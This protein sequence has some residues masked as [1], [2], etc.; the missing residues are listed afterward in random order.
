MN[1]G[2]DYDMKYYLYRLKFETPVRFGIDK[3]SS[4]LTTTAFTANSDT[5]FSAIAS[6]WARIYGSE[7]LET[8]INETMNERFVLSDLLPYKR[9]SEE[10]EIYIPKPILYLEKSKEKSLNIEEINTDK[11]KIKKITHIGISEIERYMTYLKSGG[12]ISFGMVKESIYAEISTT[13]AYVRRNEDTLPYYVAGVKFYSDAGLCFVT[14]TTERIKEKLDIVID[15]LSTSGIGGKK[16]SGFG[17]F[18]SDS[19]EIGP[20]SNSVELEL[21]KM[22][23]KESSHYI[24]ISAVLP[25]KNEID[26]VSGQNCGYQLF[27][28]K[29]FISSIDFGQGYYK[30][31]QVVMIKAGSVFK[32]KIKGKI[33]DVSDAG[34]HKVYRNGKGMYLGVEEN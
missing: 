25:E 2:G 8:F 14:K 31:K 3:A 1:N 13:K 12:K 28:R 22:L 24:S 27:L 20:N 5:V 21:W 4:N 15:S 18:I 32:Y 29:G 9:S 10:Y 6:E 11:K 33:I 34:N 23:E 30:R 16:S 19:V 7:S 17:K 26:A